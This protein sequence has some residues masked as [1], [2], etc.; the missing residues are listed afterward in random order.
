MIHHPKSTET[1]FFS[2]PKEYPI[3]PPPLVV[4]EYSASAAREVLPF[5]AKLVGTLE[6]LVGGGTY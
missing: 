3:K 1:L 2:Q 6:D 4:W 5:L